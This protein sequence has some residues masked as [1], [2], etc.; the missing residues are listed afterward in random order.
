[1]STGG[2]L[3]SA[4]VTTGDAGQ[5]LRPIVWIPGLDRGHVGRNAASGGGRP[6]GGRTRRIDNRRAVIV[7][8]EG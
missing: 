3:V 8:S 2:A 5:E 7:H 1:M 6:R 4:P